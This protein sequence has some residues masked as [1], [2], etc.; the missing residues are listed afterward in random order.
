M[1]GGGGPGGAAGWPR[2]GQLLRSAIDAGDQDEM[3]GKVYDAG[4][5]ARLTEYLGQVKCTSDTRRPGR[6]CPDGG[7]PGHAA[8]GGA[9]HQPYRR[10]Q[11]RW[12][13][14]SCRW[15]ISAFWLVIWGAQYLE[16]L[17]LSYAG[18][19][20]L[21]RMRTQMFSHLHELSLSFFDR[22]KV[23]K[24]MSRV[25]NDVDQLQTLV[26]QDF[27]KVAVNAVTL[28]G[29]AVIM[30]VMNWRLALLAL[31]TLPVLVAV[32]MVWQ[33]YARRAFIR[34]RKTIAVV[35]DNLQESISG[36][37]VTQS[38]SREAVN[39]KQF[40]AINKANLDANKK[41]AKLQGA[42]MPVTQMLTDSSYV[43]VLVFGGFQVLDGNLAVGFLLAFLLYIQR[44]SAPVQQLATMYTEIQRAMASGVRIFELID[45]EPEIKTRP[46]RSNCRR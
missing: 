37:R 2:G 36:V 30:I 25:Q 13:H 3:L 14:D 17:H 35:N 42:I 11:S 33:T 7:Q 20:I 1:Y 6:S 24:I 9:G 16:T 34:A 21:F 22:N 38:L 19:G 8:P 12:P 45:V 32:M 23:G 4:M 10:R 28:I 46:R 15:S 41:A 40:D 39:V 18:Q 31:S 44:L 29:I 26:T 27:I 43:L 5:M